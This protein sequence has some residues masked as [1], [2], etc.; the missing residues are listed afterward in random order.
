MNVTPRGIDL[1]DIKY[2]QENV[3][4]GL[5]KR[6]QLAT[7]DV[8]MTITGRVGTAAV[9]TADILPANINQHIVRLRVE[10]ARCLPQYLAAYLNTSVGLAMSNR[11]VTGGTR[12][13]VDYEAIRNLPIPLPALEVQRRI[14]EQCCRVF[15]EAR[16]LREEA[17][18][19]WQAAKRRFEEHLLRPSTGM[20]D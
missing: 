3:H 20:P 17:A 1:R 14:V 2:I 6:S 12:I 8:L 5:L 19:E 11:G 13:A 16:G 18:R 15:D 9:V 10:T 4:A 7:G